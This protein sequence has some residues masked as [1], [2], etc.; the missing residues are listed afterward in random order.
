VEGSAAARPAATGPTGSGATR[1]SRPAAAAKRRR[2]RP[3]LGS[4]LVLLIGLLITATMSIGA[5]GLRNDNED[6]LLDQRIHEAAA[7]VGA[8]VPAVQLPLASVGVTADA[9]GGSILAFEQ[10]MKR[11]TGGERRFAS[12][13][14]WPIADGATDPARRLGDR[15]KLASLP[16]ARRQAFLRAAADRIDPVLGPQMSLIDMLDGPNRR[17]G[18]AM[19]SPDR[20]YLAYAETQLPRD[21]QSRVGR[22]EAFSD[23]DYALYLGDTRTPDKLLASSTGGEGLSGRT[24]QEAV[25]FGNQQLLIVLRPRGDLGGTFLA[26]LPWYLLAAGV[27]LSVFAALLVEFLIRRREQAERLAAE[28]ERIAAEN[29]RLLSDQRTVAYT[30]QHSLLPEEL[31]TVDGLELGV[32]YVAGVEGVDVGGDWYDVIELDGDRLFFVVGDVS[33]RGLRA[34][35]VMAS[36]RYAIRAYATDGDDPATVLTKLSRLLSVG[37]DGNFATVLCGIIEVNK[38]EV[39][40]ASAGHPYP[41]LLANGHADYVTMVNGV[42]VGVT[43]HDTY[44]PVIVSVPARATLLVYTDGLVERRG[45]ALDVGFERLRAATAGDTGP[46]E[47]LL[48]TVVADVTNIESDDDT[49]LLGI[50]WTA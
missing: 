40:L 21:R 19:P 10:V 11:E 31:P 36:L 18:Y 3:H 30:L 4:V 29:A 38:R 27:V 25:P 23:L 9:T 42:P 8:A 1:Q 12:S 13:S 28:L 48:T 39:T 24:A 17:L 22:D 32:R 37:R 47:Q 43:A 7:V 6:R 16:P 33:G 50:R 49:A 41:L 44:H 2:L 20:A 35:T 34:A 14:L 46:L 15:P 26:S 45:E 5:R